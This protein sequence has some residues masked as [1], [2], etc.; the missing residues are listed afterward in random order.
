M[1]NFWDELAESMKIVRQGP[2]SFVQKTPSLAEQQISVSPETLRQNLLQKEQYLQQAFERWKTLPRPRDL[3]TFFRDE[4]YNLSVSIESYLLEEID[5]VQL[6]ALNPGIQHVQDQILSWAHGQGKYP[7]TIEA[8][9]RILQLENYTASS[10]EA[11][12]KNLNSPGCRTL[13]AWGWQDEDLRQ[14]IQFYQSAAKHAEEVHTSVASYWARS[15]NTAIK[16]LH[17]HKYTPSEITALY[18]HLDSSD[19][20]PLRNFGW[21]DDGIRRVIKF[22]QDFTALDCPSN[23]EDML[24]DKFSTNDYFNSVWRSFFNLNIKK[25]RKRGA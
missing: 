13:R 14:F 7:F 2:V 23:S 16:W 11:L 17:L 15:F 18:T 4:Q 9:S 20:N 22:Y 24:E 6:M 10:Y 3:T 21:T 19:C 12:Y 25:T 8:L 5:F 1:A